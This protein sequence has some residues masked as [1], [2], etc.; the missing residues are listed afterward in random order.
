MSTVYLRYH[1]FIDLVAGFALAALAL[2]VA[3]RFE[4]TATPQEEGESR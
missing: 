2:A 4:P 3:R 1:Y